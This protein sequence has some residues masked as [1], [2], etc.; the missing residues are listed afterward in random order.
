MKIL[1]SSDT[2]K[3]L[4]LAEK[5]LLPQCPADLL[6]HL[7]DYVEDG[8]ELSKRLGIPLKAVRGDNDFCPGDTELVLECDGVRIFLCH[9]HS[10]NIDEGLE[11]IYREAKRRQARLALFGHSHEPKIEA[12]DGVVMLN[13]GNLCLAEKKNSFAVVRIERPKIILG[14]FNPNQ[15]GFIDVREI[16][17][18]PG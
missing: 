5:A 18:C 3:S 9:G 2:H 10:C 15:K 12:R 8:Q 17:A 16:P 13:P 7:G 11:E 4:D 14:I 1:V 6:I